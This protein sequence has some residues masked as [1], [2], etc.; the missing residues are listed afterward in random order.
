MARCESRGI[1]FLS[2]PFDFESVDLLETLGVAAYK[3][4]SG[5]ITNWPFLEHVASKRKP[6]IL[7][8][9]MSHFGEVEQAVG[10]LRTAGCEELVILQCTSSYP[11]PPAS[12]NLRALRTMSDAFQAPVGLSDHTMGAEVALASV[13]LGACVIEKHFT[14]DRSLPG[15]DHQASLEP[16]ELKR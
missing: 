13:A 8:T 15:P 3:V 7:S 5:E 12:A 4:P 10:V 11:A 14:L 6:V 9:G 2:T 16:A 1:L